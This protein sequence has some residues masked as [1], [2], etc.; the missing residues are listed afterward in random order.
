MCCLGELFPG[1]EETVV[2]FP[3]SRLEPQGEWALP[4]AELL[5]VAAVC[6]Y[7]QARRIYEMGTYTGA[8]TL[9]MAMNAPADA[10]IF[11]LDLDAAERAALRITVD[12]ADASAFVVGACY[13]DTPFTDRVHQLLGNTLTFDHSPYYGTIDLVLIDANHTYPYVKRDTETAFKLLRPG[14]TII[15]D[16]YVWEEQHPECAGVAQCLNE[17]ASIYR[18]FQIR[19]TRLAIHL[20]GGGGRTDPRFNSAEVPAIR[21]SQD[22]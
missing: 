11:T 22:S 2:H 7:T 1:I 8:T 6:R 18:L 10:E 16:D 20:D 14:G 17:L 15:W 21:S 3:V 4:L 5:T 12:G 9:G 13:R 19:G